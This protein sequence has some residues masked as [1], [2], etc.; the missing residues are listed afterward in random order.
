MEHKKKTE[1]KIDHFLFLKQYSFS[2]YSSRH[3]ASGSYLGLDLLFE[4]RLRR[5]QCKIIKKC[6]VEK[7]SILLTLCAHN[8]LRA[9]ITILK[10]IFR[11][12]DDIF[13]S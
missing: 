5:N 8:K 3:V 9:N 7:L 2:N 4:S 1:M 13:T 10:S 6:N 11:C 12:T